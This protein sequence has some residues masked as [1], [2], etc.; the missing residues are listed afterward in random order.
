MAAMFRGVGFVGSTMIHTARH[1]DH[2][3]IVLWFSI[4]MR[5]CGSVSIVMG[6]RL[7]A[8]PGSSAIKVAV[9]YT[10]SHKMERSNKFMV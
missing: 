6:L 10:V 3:K 8:A 4:C 5:A 7:V 2:E 9:S 1:V